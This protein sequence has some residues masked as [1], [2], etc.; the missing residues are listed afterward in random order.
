MRGS[1]QDDMAAAADAFV[2]WWALAGVDSAVDE[3][4]VNWLRAVPM[5]T[6]R[7]GEPLPAAPAPAAL[8]L[9][10]PTTLDAFHR[11]LIA[12]PAQPERRWPGTPILPTGPVEAPLMIVTDMPDTADVAAGALLSDRAGT[13]FDAMLHAIGFRRS[14]IYLASLF[15]SR[16]PGGM[17]DTADL[18]HAATRMAAHV[19]LAAPSR[20][21]IL[22]DRTVRALLPTNDDRIGVTDDDG[23]RV[24]NHKGGNVSAIAS[25]HPRLLLTQPAAKAECWRVLQRLI[26]ETPQ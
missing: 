6:R 22:G 18:D 17:V 13:L 5:Q 24:F 1:V 10:E 4:P 7:T 2:A 25:F 16:P 3:A 14:D 15:L 19:A 11:W 9:D 8:T 12:D 23:L 20:L 26:E 21:L